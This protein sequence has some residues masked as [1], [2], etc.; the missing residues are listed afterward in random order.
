MTDAVRNTTL[1]QL[2]IYANERTSISIFL[3]TGVKLEGKIEWVDDDGF[4][5]VR[6]GNEQ[7]V[8]LHAVST[9]TPGKRT[10]SE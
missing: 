9:V 2:R 4:L 5:L 10:L 7:V 6:E 1:G 3:L 8:F